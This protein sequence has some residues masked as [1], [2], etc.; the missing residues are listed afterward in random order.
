MGK[1]LSEI[2]NAALSDADK[3][4]KIASAYDATVVDPGDFLAAELVESSKT[5]ASHEDTFSA[6]ERAGTEKLMKKHEKEMHGG[7]H[8]EH[9]ESEKGE[10]KSSAQIKDDAAYGLKLASAL[11]HS[12]YIV[13]KMAAD[14][15]PSTHPSPVTVDMGGA[16][17][18]PLHA[19]GPQVMES[20]FI[21]AQTVSPKAHSSVSDRISGPPLR[22]SDLATNKADHTGNLDGEQPRNNTGKTAGWTKSKEASARLLRAK[23]AQV[24][25]LTRLGQ[26][27]AAAA[28]LN[29]IQKEAQDPS[30][31]PP[32]LPA[33]SED[34][35]MSTEPGDST[36]IPDNATLIS[37]TKAQAKDRSVRAVAD[38]LSET[39]KLDNAVPA[40]SLT[41]QGQKVSSL[42]AVGVA[43]GRPFGGEKVAKSYEEKLQKLKDKIQSS[44][45]PEK[46]KYKA[47][48]YEAKYKAHQAKNEMTPE[49]ARA[50]LNTRPSGAKHFWGGP[51]YAEWDRN[52]REAARAFLENHARE[53]GQK[54]SSDGSVKEAVS[55]KWLTDKLVSS[56]RQ[57]RSKA[58]DAVRAGG[59]SRSEKAMDLM[60]LRHATK[61]APS[62]ISE[63]VKNMSRSE[64]KK[65][66]EGSEMKAVLRG[67]LSSDEFGQAFIERAM[68]VAHDPDADPSERVYAQQIVSAIKAKTQMD[69]EALLG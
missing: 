65:G 5:A 8:E 45:N 3:S 10:K 7:E 56:A 54:T 1:S 30:S 27:K 34:Y 23:Q 21:G 29:E 19:P 58:M 25:L 24:E 66:I 16:S 62:E 53:Q 13:A 67:K 41:A 68:K 4:L 2:V 17:H 43:L 38:Y 32:E 42:D 20:G 12:A 11:E 40:H 47:E 48:K 9:E 49:S 60:K 44:S 14:T 57:A 52:R 33:H 55:D 37:M 63:A 35:R 15:D 31:P 36:M 46:A 6:K 61:S 39:P 18:S 26:T 59:G 51:A 69:P 22:N 50:I 28:L 64:L